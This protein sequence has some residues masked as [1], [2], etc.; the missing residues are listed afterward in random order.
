MVLLRVL[1][2]LSVCS[3]TSAGRFG[4]FAR[5]GCLYFPHFSLRKEYIDDVMSIVLSVETM[6][7]HNFKLRASLLSDVTRC[8]DCCRAARARVKA[9]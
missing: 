1:I 4:A 7:N 2:S 8:F 5:V 3:I 9:Y 6:S